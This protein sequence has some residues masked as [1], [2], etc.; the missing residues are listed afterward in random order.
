MSAKRVDKRAEYVK[1]VRALNHSF[2]AWF[3]DSISKSAGA[4]LAVGAQNWIDYRAKLEDRYLRTHG[5]VLTFGSGDCGQLAHGMDNDEDLAVKFPRI[6]YSLRDKK[7]CWV[8]CGG[9]HNAVVT[10]DGAVHTW[11][12]NDDGSLGRAGEESIPGIVEGIPK[13]DPVIGVDCGDAHTVAVTAGGAVYA[14][15]CFKDKEGKKW[16]SPRADAASPEQTIK[17]QC[18][19]AHRVHGLPKMVEVAAGAS[20]CIGL[21]DD[22]LVWSWGLGES[23]ELG[24]P[25]S[26]MKPNGA[27]SG[28]DH[29]V[30]LKD[31]LTP[32]PMRIGNAP[33]RHAR[34]IG[35]GAYHTL[36]VAGS[37][38]T[39]AQKEGLYT[40]GLS[41]YGQLGLGD[42]TNQDL[43]KHV[44]CARLY[45]DPSTGEPDN[46]QQCC[47][48]MHHS[49]ALLSS[50]RVF[51][52]G[53]AD[54][55]QLGLA[56]FS[57]NTEAGD[58]ASSPEHIVLE[59][60]GSD[61]VQSLASGGSHNLA[62]TRGGAI[63]SWG[64]GDMLALGH[65]KEEDEP[66][67][68]KVNLA[69]AKVGD[70]RV[71][72]VAAGGQ[73]SALIGTVKTV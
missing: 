44:D 20:Y 38:S 32:A 40:C 68:R 19:D 11:G 9:L 50:G 57:K 55:G 34:A 51:A 47:G 23:G 56:R 46:V 21:A 15:G 52:W 54:Y 53:R 63:Y 31:H 7:V 41:N 73:H 30:I 27:D 14:W 70:L 45:L 33:V 8:A 1:H 67:P 12:C 58:S 4:C 59:A 37:D 42:N 6:V 66:L 69:K 71:T 22:G 60:W 36:V 49:T 35:C 43:L 72:Q 18:D 62:L 39:H 5:E 26:A 10:E 28:Y 65:G 2:Q 3:N 13:D 61:P 17:R 29:T 16:F 25:V 48:G 64:Y 24:R